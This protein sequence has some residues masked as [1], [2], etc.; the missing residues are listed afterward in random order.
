M[1]L[2]K[3]IDQAD[4]IAL[5]TGDV[6]YTFIHFVDAPQLV[7]CKTLK[8]CTEQLQNF[9]RIHKR[10]AINPKYIEKVIVA[11]QEKASVYIG[12]KSVP[13]SRRRTKEVMMKLWQNKAS[14]LTKT[15]ETVA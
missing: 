15:A 3:L 5:L 14:W 4:R 9:I 8:E 12:G 7:I 11:D 6:N 13:I 2:P 1:A 10:Y